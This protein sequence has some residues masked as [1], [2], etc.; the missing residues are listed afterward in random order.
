MTRSSRSRSAAWLTA[1]LAVTM[2]VAGCSGIPASGPAQDI[3]PIEQPNAPVSL[4]APPAGQPADSIVRDFISH[5]T[6]TTQDVKAASSLAFARQ[7][8]TADASSRWHPD[9]SPVVVLRNDFRVEIGEKN[10]VELKGV[11]IATLGVD[12]AYHAVPGRPYQL[13][14][15]L[16]KVSG[17][18]RISDP[19]ADLLVTE[20]D[21]TNSYKERVVYFLNRTGTVL[22]PD[23]RYVILGPTP[24]NRADRLVG[25]LLAGPSS[26][27]AKAGKS[28]T[29]QLG[30]AS[31]RSPVTIQD[32]LV[33]V[34]LKG[35]DLSGQGARMALAAQLAWTLVSEGDV[36]ITIDGEP[37]DP[38][39]PTFSTTNT[40][41]FSPD[42]TPGSGN[43][44][45]DP[46]YVDPGGRVVSLAGKAIWGSIGTSGS[47][48]S[49]A[50]SAANG[51][52]A[53]VSNAPNGPGQELLMGKP[54]QYQNAEPVLAADT[55]TTPSI[56]RA[57]NE[58]WVVQDGAT[59]PQVIRLTTSSPVTRQVIDAP[60]LAGKGAVTALVLSPDGV[61]VAVVADQ[62]LYV[63][64]INLSVPQPEDQATMSITD[65]VEIDPELGDVGPIAFRSAA[66]L[67]VGAKVGSS[68]SG[69][70][71]LYQVSIDGQERNEVSSDGIFGDVTA[72]ASGLDGTMLTAFDGR[73]WLL[74]GTPRSGQWISPDPRTAVVP[75]SS[76]F[77]PN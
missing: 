3:R 58:V 34:D 20:T 70:R 33:R 60:G 30:E 31:L 2:I 17:E 65:L 8:L 66:E 25:M 4:S 44:T 28:A 35:V 42:R 19:P 69:F 68:S 1:L 21:F 47:V 5:A 55:L 73:V 75:G 27:L 74:D 76:P 71:L 11:Q 56:D 13:V 49:A 9:S 45:L 23:P 63:G 12:H 72:V 32:N 48:V 18:W 41:S 40:A 64:V 51:T 61:R 24:A 59:K 15:H 22:V 37:L 10:T 54:L 38:Q 67:L 36:A 50:M 46:Y 43:L 77:L 62:K 14:L 7:Y 53:A 57:G 16:A 39:I 29:S 52:I 6:D 26:T